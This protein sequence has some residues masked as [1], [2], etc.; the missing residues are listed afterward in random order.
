M[1]AKNIPVTNKS[2]KEIVEWIWENFIPESGQS[3]YVQSEVLRA[4][5]KLRWEAQHNGNM[6]W[7]DGFVIFIDYIEEILTSDKKM[8]PEVVKQVKTDLERLRNFETPTKP[9]FDP[10]KLPY[11]ENDLYNRLFDS[12][13]SYCRLNPVLIKRQINPKQHR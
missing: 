3:N 11:V 12:L 7:D 6:N 10:K 13:A 4:I 8:D 1:F 5:E 2:N 9:N